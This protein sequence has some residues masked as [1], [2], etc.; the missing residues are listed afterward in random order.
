MTDPCAEQAAFQELCAYTLTHGD[1]FFIHQL[2]VDAWAAQ[3][4]DGQTKPIALTFALLGL[5]LAVE[6]GVTGRQVQRA[7]MQLGR[8]KH[9]WPGLVL[10]DDRGSMT[11]ADVMQAPAGPDRDRAIHDWCASVWTA[12]GRNRETIVNV[13]NDHG[14]RLGQ[15]TTTGDELSFPESTA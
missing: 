9:Q 6:Q 5:Y 15:T 2:V 14:V 11:A 7:H 4:A 12:F 10:P 8:K 1:P 3:H 13:L